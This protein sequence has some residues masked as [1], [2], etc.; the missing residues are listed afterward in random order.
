MNPFKSLNLDPMH[1]VAAVVKNSLARQSV[2]IENKDV[3]AA[4]TQVVKDL[5]IQLPVA[6]AAIVPVKS[7]WR[8]KINWAQ[9][10]GP[11]ASLVTAFLFPLTADQIVAVVLG[12]QTLQSAATWALRTFWTTSVTP[13]SLPKA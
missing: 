9:V 7:A 2:Q 3:P 13:A 6:G 10:A 5:E 11:V 12:F 4:V 8:S 1:L